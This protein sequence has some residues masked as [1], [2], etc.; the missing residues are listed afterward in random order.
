MEV[1][2]A[3][4][5][6]PC[7]SDLTSRPAHCTAEETEAQKDREPQG[8]RGC[9]SFTTPGRLPEHR[10]DGPALGARQAARRG[11][12]GGRSP[13]PA[14]G[15]STR[16]AHAYLATLLLHFPRRAH[17]ACLQ[18]MLVDQG[19]QLPAFP[20]LGH[21]GETRPVRSPARPPQSPPAT[22]LVPLDLARPTSGSFFAQGAQRAGKCSLSSWSG[23][24]R[25]GGA[26]RAEA[27][28]ITKPPIG[29]GGRGQ[30]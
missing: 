13:N 23:R 15:P 14:R 9:G 27:W 2:A 24:P 8:G 28:G 20:G 26:E 10:R 7:A 4:I 18:Q 30:T 19:E 5:T 29:G 3:G 1:R 17:I 12:A 22:S 16:P 6:K 11:G 21:A 25:P